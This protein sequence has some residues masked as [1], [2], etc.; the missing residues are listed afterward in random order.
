MLKHILA[1]EDT[2]KLFKVELYSDEDHLTTV[3]EQEMFI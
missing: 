1:S 3:A 2:L